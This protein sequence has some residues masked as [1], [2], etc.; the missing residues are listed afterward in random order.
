[1][2]PVKGDGMEWSAAI[3]FPRSRG[4][5][6]DQVDDA[7]D[8]LGAMIQM[9][10]V[11]YDFPVEPAPAPSLQAI[12]AVARADTHQPAVTPATPGAAPAAEAAGPSDVE[13]GRRLFNQNC[14]HCHGPDAVQGEQR[15]NLRLL[16]QSHVGNVHDDGDAWTG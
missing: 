6:R 2:G 15:R 14:S 1:M 10:A 16:R 4:E 3:A 12:T 13:A 9:L 7:L 8:R 5:L 11:K